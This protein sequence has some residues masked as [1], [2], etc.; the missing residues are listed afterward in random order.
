MTLDTVPMPDGLPRILGVMHDLYG[1]ELQ[2]IRGGTQVSLQGCPYKSVAQLM[3]GIGER[4]DHH[5]K[6]PWAFQGAWTIRM[7]KGGH[8]IKHNHPQ[9]DVSGVYYV[10]IG[11][12]ADLIVDG[13]VLKPEREMLVLF[14]SKAPH[15]TTP[16]E[17]DEPRMTVAFDVK[18]GA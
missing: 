4:L 17:G 1:K 15:E 9:G 14:P 13:D 2:T 18:V 7:Q 8:H 11:P 10:A 5:L 6:A 16:Y 12:G 3:R